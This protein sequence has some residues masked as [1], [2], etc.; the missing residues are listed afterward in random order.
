MDKDNT[1][2]NQNR[3]FRRL[4]FLGLLIATGILIFIKLSPLLGAFLGAS[5]L[6][7]LL[8]KMMFGLVEKHGWKKWLAALTIVIG[9]S[10]IFVGAML[11]IFEIVAAEIQN[12][13]PNEL[14][15]KGNDIIASI[16]SKLNVNLISYKM[17]DKI[18]PI[19]TEGAGVLINATYNFAIGILFMILMLYFMLFSGR[20]METALKCYLPFKGESRRMLIDE[21]AGI[22]YNNALVIPLTML[23]QGLVAAL[24][25]WIFGLKSVVLMAFL[26]AVCGLLPMVGTIIV[27]VPL[28][29]SL[30]MQGDVW[31]G[32]ALMACGLIII[33]NIDNLIRI[34]F[35]QRSTNTH[36][37]IVILGILIGIPL[38][39][40]W[41]I[42]FGPLLISIFLLLI[43]IYY[44]EYDL[45]SQDDIRNTN[46][47]K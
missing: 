38:F 23:S 20:S 17:L 4:L 44:M 13:H 24:I 36:P 5:T 42:I 33:A 2:S 30:V 43:K 45:L 32:I 18:A 26:T 35:N 25:Y 14:L 46:I 3:F 7:I 21:T 28:G 41:G 11:G 29:L 6:Y 1:I 22:I 15:E 27:S 8:R 19:L 31:Q 10:L 37:L 16:N 9:V 12:I 47:V 39:G 40:F 34:I